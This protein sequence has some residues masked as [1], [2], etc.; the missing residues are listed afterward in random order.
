M[1]AMLHELKKTKHPFMLAPICIAPS[2]SAVMAAA[3]AARRS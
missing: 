3:H 2:V 1:A